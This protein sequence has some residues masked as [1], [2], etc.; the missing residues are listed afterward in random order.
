VLYTIKLLSLPCKTIRIVL[1]V[2]TKLIQSK[3]PF[4][5]HYPVPDTIQGEKGVRCSIIHNCIDQI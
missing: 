3:Y 4:E 1:K 2:E 5:L